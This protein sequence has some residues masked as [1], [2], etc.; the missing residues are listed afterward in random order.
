MSGVTHTQTP[1]KQRLQRDQRR[2]KTIA[3]AAVITFTALLVTLVLVLDGG[4]SP[5]AGTEQQAV[6]AQQAGAQPGVRPDGA[7]EEG[8]AALTRRAAPA[9]FDPN[10]I[11]QPPGQRYDGGP[12]ETGVAA[13]IAP[14]PEPTPAPAPPDG[15][16][17]R[18]RSP[19]A[20]GERLRGGDPRVHGLEQAEKAA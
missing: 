3:L 12:E 13:G 11:K 10:S 7:P 16:Q 1:M 20:R 5:T 6:E 18:P 2:A 14:R 4:D 17:S 8:Q 19:A 15:A 9:T